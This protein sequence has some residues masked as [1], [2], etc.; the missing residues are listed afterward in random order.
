MTQAYAALLKVLGHL[1]QLAQINN[2]C[3]HSSDPPFVI[4]ASISRLR[5]YIYF[6]CSIAFVQAAKAN[7]FNPDVFVQLGHYHKEVT[8][9]RRCV[10]ALINAKDS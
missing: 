7:P 4:V 6:S 1:E 5:V 9:D 2:N 3:L 8:K 10:L